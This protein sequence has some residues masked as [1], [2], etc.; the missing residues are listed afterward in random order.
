MFKEKFGL[1]IIGAAALAACSA[2]ADKTGADTPEAASVMKDTGNG[3]Y[4]IT[5]PQET[6]SEV[7]PEVD[8]ST[9]I[10]PQ[11]NPAEE[12][13]ILSGTTQELD[14]MPSEEIEKLAPPK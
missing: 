8:S 13:K 14:G 6:G 1:G 3:N 7:N 12:A 11:Y 2:E 5:L 4:E 10:P 9:G